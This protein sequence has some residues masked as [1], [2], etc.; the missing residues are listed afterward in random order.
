M[1]GLG[2]AAGVATVLGVV[3]G[4]PE[5]N[6]VAPCIWGEASKDV[7]FSIQLNSTKKVGENLSYSGSQASKIAF[8]SAV[9]SWIVVL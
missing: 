1:E 9:A 3:V 7:V 4:P 6:T 5:D 2:T 8:I